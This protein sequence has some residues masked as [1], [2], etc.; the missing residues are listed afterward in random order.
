MLKF[1]NYVTFQETKNPETSVEIKEALVTTNPSVVKLSDH[2]DG[3]NGNYGG[4]EQ[5]PLLIQQHPSYAINPADI[6]L[7]L[8]SH[9]PPSSGHAQN[10]EIDGAQAAEYFYAKKPPSQMI[11]TNYENI[12][13]C[14][15]LYV[16]HP[17]NSESTLSLTNQF[18]QR[19]AAKELPSGL[20]TSVTNSL[21]SENFNVPDTDPNYQSYQLPRSPQCFIP[22]NN[23]TEHMPIDH[24]PHQNHQNG[25]VMHHMQH[26]HSMN[27]Q[28]EHHYHVQRAMDPIYYAKN[29]QQQSSVEG[30]YSPEPTWPSRIPASNNG[31]AKLTPHMETISNRTIPPSSIMKPPP[32]T[33]AKAFTRMTSADLM[34]YESFRN[35]TLSNGDASD[36]PASNDHENGHNGCNDNNENGM[37]LR[38]T[39]GTDSNQNQETDTD[40]AIEDVESCIDGSVDDDQNHTNTRN[41]GTRNDIGGVNV[42]KNVR[43]GR[44]WMFGVH[45]NPKVVSLK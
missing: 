33:Y 45:K 27:Q 11:P 12:N 18:D 22:S 39:N 6:H 23:R 3:S 28:P 37:H 42:A 44:P 36:E 13:L 16:T 34:L 20:R 14:N 32:Y 21:I 2:I 25:Y 15:S 38:P 41:F 31:L 8:Q 5:E 35:K 29:N 1:C 17:S 30:V 10:D 7:M 19:Y 43:S 4:M 40:D 26:Q 9:Q 24:H